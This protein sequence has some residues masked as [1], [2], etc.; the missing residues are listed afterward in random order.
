MARSNSARPAACS[1]T[2]SGFLLTNEIES[3][4]KGRQ[5]GVLRGAIRAGARRC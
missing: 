3:M 5:A 2:T 1:T 4:D